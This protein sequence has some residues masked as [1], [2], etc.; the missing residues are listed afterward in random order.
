MVDMS[1]AIEVDNLSFGYKRRQRILQQVSFVVESGT[2]LAIVGPNG[3]G[4][5]TLL[6]LLCRTLKADSGRILI[7]ETKID[8]YS[9]RTLAR[10]VAVVRQE[11]APV[12][13]F[14]VAETVAM[15]R[16]P[17]RRALGFPDKDDIGHIQD[18]LQ[19]TETA[20]LADRSMSNLSGGERQRV[21]IARALAQDTDI[22]LLD[23]PTSFLDL[24]HQV[25]IYDLLKTAQRDRRRT[26]VAVSH[27]VNLALQYSDNVLLLG[28]PDVHRCGP[29]RDVLTV[30]QMEQIF[31]CRIRAGR[32]GTGEFFMPLG[33][34]GFDAESSANTVGPA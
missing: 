26:I 17:Y 29:A 11:S 7:H 14:S 3:A 34:Y 22:L 23:E 10:K 19:I 9:H 20:H 1:N 6:N 31:G 2:F 5:S 4:K 24:K 21:Y 28:G 25:A 15:A 13:T 8:S 27:D 16:I 30:G 32:L 18:A 33:K 12:F